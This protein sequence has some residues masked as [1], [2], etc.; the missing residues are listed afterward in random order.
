[1]DNVRDLECQLLRGGD[2]KKEK[3]CIIHAGMRQKKRNQ[4]GK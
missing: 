4:K 3:K 2:L 1:M